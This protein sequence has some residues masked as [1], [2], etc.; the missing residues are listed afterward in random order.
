MRLYMSH[1]IPKMQARLD[2]WR[3]NPKTPTAKVNAP[4]N[5]FVSRK[6]YGDEFEEE[7]ILQEQKNKENHGKSTRR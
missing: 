5:P 4:S 1:L 6:D 2:K 3:A 7:R